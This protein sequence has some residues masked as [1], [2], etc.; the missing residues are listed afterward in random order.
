MLATLSANGFKCESEEQARLKLKEYAERLL[1]ARF[2]VAARGA[3]GLPTY[4]IYEALVMGAIPIVPW[5]PRH[6]FLYEE[7]PVVRVR[8]DEWG[9]VTPKFLKKQWHKIQSAVADGK[10]DMRKLYTPYWIARLTVSRWAH[11]VGGM[12][13]AHALLAKE[14]RLE[15]APPRA[16]PAR[17]QSAREPGRK[18]PGAV[19]S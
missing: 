8:D 9:R 1:N 17:A 2:V 11:E 10:Y 12:D 3:G 4:R 5:D 19:E 7:L 15:T 13:A 14:V 16:Q 6:E 18:R